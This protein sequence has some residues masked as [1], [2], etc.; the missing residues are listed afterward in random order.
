M[1][2]KLVVCRCL[3]EG[4]GTQTCESFGHVIP[5]RLV[6]SQ[7]FARHRQR[8]ESAQIH[9]Q[10]NQQQEAQAQAAKPGSSQLTTEAK[11]S[12][13]ARAKKR[14]LSLSV[15]PLG[16]QNEPTPI[17][18]TL[19]ASQ[20]EEL[21]SL[22]ATRLNSVEGVSR[23]TGNLILRGIQFIISM[24]LLLVHTALLSYGLAL[25]FTPINVPRDLRTAY[26]RCSID[27]EITRTICCPECFTTYS[28]RPFSERC[29]WKESSFTR[30][31]NTELWTTRNTPH[32]P[33]RV[34]R[35][36]YSTQSFD[37]WLTFFLSRCS[38]VE[39]LEKA[40]DQHV[41][42]P[43]V[44]GAK[45]HDVQDSPAWR[46]L[47]G[48]GST[49]FDL[50]FGIYIDWFNPFTNKIAG[51]VV[52][53]GAIVLYCLNLPPH[54]RYRPENVFIAGMTPPPHSPSF[55][56]I[57]H[58]LDPIFESILRYNAPGKHVPVY[59][60]QAPQVVTVRAIPL[61]ADLQASRKVSGYVS[62]SAHLF[63][64]FCL[65]HSGDVESLDDHPAR[66][67]ETVCAEANDW[68]TATT[69]T[70]RKELA[71][72]NGVRWTPM[73]RLPYYNPVRHVILGF[74]HNWLEGILQHHLRDLF[75]IGRDEMAAAKAKGRDSSTVV[76]KDEQWTESDAAESAEELDDL[77]H[78]SAEFAA[79]LASTTDRMHAINLHAMD[80][81]SLSTSSH[82]TTRPAAIRS[83]TA[84]SEPV[85]SSSTLSSSGLPH[86]YDS[87]DDDA[88]DDDYGDWMRSLP[89]PLSSDVKPFAFSKDELAQVRGTIASVWLP[90]WVERPPTN[91][92]ESSHGKLK[93]RTYLTLFSAILP[94]KLP[95]FWWNT[96]DPFKSRMFRNFC[97]LVAATNIQASFTTS[98]AQA[99]AYTA[100]YRRYRATLPTLFSNHHSKPNH[101][102]AMHSGTSM[103]KY[104]GPLPALSEFPGERMN[105]MLQRI[106]TNNHQSELDLTMMRQMCRRGRL[107]AL[108]HDRTDNES[109]QQLLKILEGEGEDSPTKSL[110]TDTTSASI[111]THT[112]DANAITQFLRKAP[113]LPVVEYNAL[114][115]YLLSTGRQYRSAYVDAPTHY[116]HPVLHKRAEHLKSIKL[117]DPARGDGKS[118]SC[119]SS[120]QSGSA[121]QFFNPSTNQLDTGYIQHI[122]R[123][124]LHNTLHTFIGIQPHLPLSQAEEEL[125]PY[126]HNPELQCRLVDQ[127]PSYTVV[128]AEPSHIITHISVAAKP[129]G[130]FGI[131][132][133]TLAV[134]WAM[135]RNRRTV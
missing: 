113:Q 50:V 26:A 82:S 7:Q 114:L 65:C 30:A 116:N 13:G 5:G 81:D 41:Q 117:D 133:P 32:G 48:V 92:G 38:I 47:Q 112:L 101:H 126:I 43:Y 64:S 19:P 70:E 127:A 16:S 104:W 100:H 11:E 25:S 125:G 87:S 52:S 80:V 58:I 49:P 23:R 56:T 22:L 99:D 44:H 111:P 2:S 77:A 129:E 36:Y 57:A 132:R 73:F 107:T 122:W 8:D 33:K 45:M 3:T 105:G 15:P 78:E 54:L 89:P 28:S 34:P 1:P 21:C 20:I 83:S 14:R 39:G 74:M 31:C 88:D 10:Y 85:S 17:E 66:D 135:G 124:L 103:L 4:C 86:L 119:Y 108:L 97:D 60:H 120:H 40:H 67:A 6:T 46:D 76:D 68:Y 35:R 91:L 51:K 96:D 115:Q 93:A 102:Y 61:I 42:N 106:K 24:V 109:L 55:V 90:P 69:K 134:C 95:D 84:P 121:I 18:I 71:T 130:L 72:R 123:V 29:T 75:G 53:C 62:H 37:S 79:A 128:V 63:C 110:D 12:H 9:A 59:G 94:L 98:N 27:P 118:Y 131:P